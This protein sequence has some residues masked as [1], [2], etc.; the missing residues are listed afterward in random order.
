MRFSSFD[1]EI[2]T[3]VNILTRLPQPSA[4]HICLHHLSNWTRERD[5]SKIFINL[6]DLYPLFISQ[7][8]GYTVGL[9]VA[10]ARSFR[11][12]QRQKIVW[13]SCPPQPCLEDMRTTPFLIYIETF[14][15]GDQFVVTHWTHVEVCLCQIYQ[16][17]LT[18][19]TNQII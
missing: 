5:W 10:I 9:R 14:L 16:S 15:R 6:S 1:T 2:D 4:R 17:V 7:H 12:K 13:S 8:E 11:G 19:L 3:N 18:S